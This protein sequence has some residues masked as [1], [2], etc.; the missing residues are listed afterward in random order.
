MVSQTPNKESLKSAQHRG[1]LLV[2]TVG[3]RVR[4]ILNSL[5]GVQE[6]RGPQA[7]FPWPNKLWRTQ[8]KH[9]KIKIVERVIWLIGRW[10][11]VP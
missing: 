4:E 7:G 10:G 3:G 5:K 9:G 6:Q 8:N 2:E 11:F 1:F